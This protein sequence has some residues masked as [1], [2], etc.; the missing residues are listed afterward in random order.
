MKVIIDP[1]GSEK[2]FEGG[3]GT[4]TRAYRPSGGGREDILGLGRTT[5]RFSFED[6]V[7]EGYPW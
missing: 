4:V 3:V 1:Q 2:L 7:R 5:S 6:V